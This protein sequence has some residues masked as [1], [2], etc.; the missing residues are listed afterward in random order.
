MPNCD[1]LKA[2]LAHSTWQVPARR[3]RGTKY[4]F[5]MKVFCMKLAGF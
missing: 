5:S 1:Y 3:F 2:V 4:I